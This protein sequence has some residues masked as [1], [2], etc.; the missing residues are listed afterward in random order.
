M[1]NPFDPSFDNIS[2]VPLNSFDIKY[3]YQRA[4]ARSGKT[5]DSLTLMKMT[6]LTKGYAY[7]FQDLGYY[8]W[9]HFDMQVT[10]EDVDNVLSLFKHDLFR[11]AYTKIITELSPTDQK[12]LF[13]MAKSQKNVVKISDI[14]QKMGKSTNYISQYRKRLIDSQVIVEAGYGKV[15]FSLPFMGEFILQMAE[16]YG[17]DQ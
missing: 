4:F 6:K 12:F 1:K 17:M 3:R 8:V 13:I 10:E 15:A 9:Q 14:R 11:N 7:A 16:L 2:L 5:I